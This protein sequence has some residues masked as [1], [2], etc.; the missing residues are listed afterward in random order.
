MAMSPC[1]FDAPVRRYNKLNQIKSAET[2]QMYF[3]RMLRQ[4]KRPCDA[5]ETLLDDCVNP[6]LSWRLYLVA[7]CK[8]DVVCCL[9]TVIGQ[10]ISMH[11]WNL[12]LLYSIFFLLVKFLNSSV[13]LLNFLFQAL[14]RRKY[15][16]EKDIIYGYTIIHYCHLPLLFNGG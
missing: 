2:W 6:S 4:F 3:E 5:Y 7:W 16:I 15:N 13:N 1:S 8:S 12:Y 10:K 11:I 14:D 9:Y